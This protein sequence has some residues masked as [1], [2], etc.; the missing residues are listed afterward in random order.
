[1]GNV[2]RL[3]AFAAASIWILGACS[4]GPVRSFSAGDELARFDF[5]EPATFE[6][7][8]YADAT[9]RIVDG[10]YRITVN[11]GDNEVWWSQWGDSVDNVVVDVAVEQKSE[12]NENAY[13]IGCRMRGHV[14]QDM[15]VDP[16]LA[17]IVSGEAA[18]PTEAVTSDATA[19]VTEEATSE[20]TEN[21]TE[22]ATEEATEAATEEATQETTAEATE[23]ASPEAE[24][25]PELANG[26]GYLFMIQGSGSFAIL[27]A[28]G[29]DITPLVNWTPSALIQQGVA[30]NELRVVCMGDYLALYINGEFAGDATDSTYSSGQVGLAA[31]AANRL[32]VQVEFDDLVVRQA[33]S[34]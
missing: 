34:G 9:L 13:G 23:A 30:R 15:A 14:G 5:S 12:A 28:R 16:T 17:A 7:G 27:R 29:R 33:V 20:A 32:G 3:I 19:E 31:S 4:S 10:V 26:D 11:E 22:E 21:A 25:T 8:A 18:E 2:V 24:A 6:E 1:V